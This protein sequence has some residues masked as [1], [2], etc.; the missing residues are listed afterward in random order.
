MFVTDAAPSGPPVHFSVDELLPRAITLKWGY[1]LEDDRNGVIS[2]FRVRFIESISN[3]FTDLEVE[4][5]TITIEEVKPFTLYY[6]EVAAFTMV[7]TGP[8][9]ARIRVLTP[10]DGE[11][12]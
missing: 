7:G 5:A 10:E 9:S 1:P 8:Y 3:N 11:R 2:G 6:A 4:N 12:I